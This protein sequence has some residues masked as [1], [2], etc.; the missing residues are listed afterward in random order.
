MTEA[1]TNPEYKT[2][3]AA[4]SQYDEA[5]YVHDD[6]LVGDDAYDALKRAVAALEEEQGFADPDSPTQ[7]VSGRVDESTFAKVAHHQK[8][9]SLDNAFSDED[10][11]KWLEGLGTFEGGFLRNVLWELK[12][13][14]L[15][16]SVIYE[17]GKM[18]RAAT[19]GD[20]TMGEDVTAQARHIKDLPLTI[21][22]KG[23]L[24][25]RGE[26]YMSH[27]DFKAFLAAETARG[28][29]KLPA[30][31]RN[32]AAGTLRQT[33][34]SKVRERGLCFMAFG[35]SDASFPDADDDTFVLS[36]LGNLGFS[37]V[38]HSLIIGGVLKTQRT[39]EEIAEVRKDLDFDIDGI[40]FKVN[41]RS[42]RAELGSTSR[43]PRWAIAYK[44]PPEQVVTT[45]EKI[46]VQVGRTGAQTP[47]AKLTPVK[48]G[49]VT[50]SSVTLHNEDEVNRLALYEGCKVKLQRAG[51]VIPQITGLA[52]GEPRIKGF[53]RMPDTC[54][55][56]GSPTHRPEGEAVIRCTNHVTC[57][58]QLQGHLEHFVSRK[59]MN[60]DGLGPSQIEDLIKYL[61]LASASQIM[62]LP[63]A[64][65][66]DF[67]PEAGVEME[68]MLV[69]EAVELWEGYGKSSASKLMKAIKKARS[70]DLA[71]FIFA[72]GIRNV[73]ETT[74]KD[75]AK[76]LG[77]V[78]A[79]FDCIT[80]DGGFVEAGVQTIDGIGPIVM[81]SLE[82]HFANK[83]NYD[84]VFAL[85]LVCDIKDMPK[86]NVSDVQPLAGEVVCFTGT[87]DRWSRDQGLL[88]ASELGAKTTNSAAKSTSILIIGAN[89]GAK[90][91]EA[92]EKNGCRV[93]EE[94]EFIALVEQAIV[95]GYKLDVMD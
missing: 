73:G 38:P 70:P 94:G 28:A 79:F 12:M 15:S 54:G 72:L 49:G 57:P 90:K 20:G 27:E 34:L 65:V 23:F 55:S 6:P 37:V 69:V 92:A 4:L 13:D 16:L 52:D 32:S 2:M 29:K 22:Y 36:A 9:E 56:C 81:A 10:M 67:I 43:A 46:V 84:E 58:A 86:A 3:L 91:I 35:V 62:E 45:L 50:V 95:D 25:V 41:E 93:M 11:G 61:G 74:A 85:R 87:M 39:I 42:I 77:T 47:V 75:I 31:C 64:Y 80:F 30:N 7:K 44:F 19:R 53:Y 5:Y 21:S 17:G 1:V 8:M 83:A 89:V 24:E 78:D 14:G 66:S 68:D 59:A 40:V 60:I 48:V 63:E 71:R 51:D 76:H 26:C 82:S 88:I 18:V 33:D